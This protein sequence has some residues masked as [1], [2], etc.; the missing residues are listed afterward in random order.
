M[1]ELPDRELDRLLKVAYAPVEVSSDF[2]LQLWRRLMAQPHPWFQTKTAAALLS[3]A[4][5]FG[6][7]AGLQVRP[8]PT[9]AGP[10]FFAR[11]VLTQAERLDLFG[12]APLDTLAGSYLALKG[13]R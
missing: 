6:V 8:E 11:S 5:V 13:R 12:N 3:V 9:P 2:T 7:S 4:V 10:R 1:K